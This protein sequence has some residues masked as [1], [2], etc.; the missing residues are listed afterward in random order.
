M[1]KHGIILV[2]WCHCETDESDFLLRYEEYLTLK[3]TE[4]SSAIFIKRHKDTLVQRGCLRLY[5]NKV[6]V[7][8][9]IT[10]VHSR[11]TVKKVLKS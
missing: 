4:K 11:T 2:K 3:G 5:I 1:K 6:V 10:D 8:D 9:T 7:P